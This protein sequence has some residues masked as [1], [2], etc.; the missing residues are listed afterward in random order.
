MTYFANYF[1]Y[2]FKTITDDMDC[3][4]GYYKCQN[5]HCIPLRMVCNGRKD[6]PMMEDELAC[7][8]LTKSNYNTI[9][10]ITILGHMFGGRG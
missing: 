1:D 2:I 6:C 3:P 5:G 4:D 8:M 9:V 7:G 10:V